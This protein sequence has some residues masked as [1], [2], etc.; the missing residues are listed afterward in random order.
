[1]V[2][3]THSDKL[4]CPVLL[5]PFFLFLP[6]FL[7]RR[8]NHSYAGSYEQGVQ[9][10]PPPRAGRMLLC[11]LSNQVIHGTVFAPGRRF[12]VLPTQ[13]KAQLSSLLTFF[14]SEHLKS[15]PQWQTGPEDVFQ[16]KPTGSNP[17]IGLFAFLLPVAEMQAQFFVS[18]DALEFEGLVPDNRTTHRCVGSRLR[19]QQLLLALEFDLNRTWSVLAFGL[20]RSFAAFRS[21]LTSHESVR[22]RFQRIDGNPVHHLH[23]EDLGVFRI[24]FH[25]SFR[26]L[27]HPARPGKASRGARQSETCDR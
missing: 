1:M 24:V 15:I 2:E 11:L 4:P 3:T 7:Q 9:W 26:R 20:R 22:Q 14:G 6:L 27:V 19:P 12:H 8:Y 5:I 21:T 10:Q 16:V 23:L 13:V 17:S 18:C 25:L